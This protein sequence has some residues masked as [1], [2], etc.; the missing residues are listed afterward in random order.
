MANRIPTISHVR[1]SNAYV[2]FFIIENIL[3]VSSYNCLKSRIGS[4]VSLKIVFPTFKSKYVKEQI[5]IPESVL[6]KKKETMENINLGYSYPD[7][8]Y[9]DYFILV[10]I[11]DYFWDKYFSDI[12]DTSIIS[13]KKLISKLLEVSGIRNSV[14]HN[15]FLS[16]LDFAK[17]QD[18]YTI[19]DGAINVKYIHNYK[20]MVYTI[21]DDLREIIVH[22]IKSMIMLISERKVVPPKYITEIKDNLFSLSNII[23]IR[24]DITHEYE[25]VKRIILEYNGMSR[26]PGKGQKIKLFVDQTDL[27]KKLNNVIEGIYKL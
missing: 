14:A 12:F 18:L 13:K 19:I 2:M 11:L 20:S 21:P 24:A 16:P 4:N 9:L 17:I 22:R 25:N 5:D 23:V 3:R 26:I 1:Q 6:K 27:I 8:W 7:F 15:R 10:V